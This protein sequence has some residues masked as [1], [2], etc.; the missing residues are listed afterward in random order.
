MGDMMDECFTW[1]SDWKITATWDIG[2]TRRILKF[3][4]TEHLSKATEKHF[5]A[6]GHSVS[7][8]SIVIF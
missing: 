1:Y 8:L 3:G 5:N 7:D 4:L 6:H 2:E